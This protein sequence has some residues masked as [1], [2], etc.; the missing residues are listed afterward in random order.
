MTALS[1]QSDLSQVHRLSFSQI[2]NYLN[3]RGVSN[4]NRRIQMSYGSGFNVFINL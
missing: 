1:E 2:S 3:R 4:P